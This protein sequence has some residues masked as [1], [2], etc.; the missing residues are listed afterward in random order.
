MV[1]APDRFRPGEAQDGSTLRLRDA[2]NVT[3]SNSEFVSKEEN[4]TLDSLSM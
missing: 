4:F 3:G 2:D 1:E